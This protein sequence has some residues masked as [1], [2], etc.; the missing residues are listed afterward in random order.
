MDKEE[1]G[2]NPKIQL[3]SYMEAPK[4]IWGDGIGLLFRFMAASL[5]AE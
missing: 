2:G 1:G 4:E 5:F 3:T